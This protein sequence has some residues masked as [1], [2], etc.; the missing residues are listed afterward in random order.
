MLRDASKKQ[1]PRTSQLK[2]LETKSQNDRNSQ[3]HRPLLTKH[4]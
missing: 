2:T 1:M 4:D 3:N